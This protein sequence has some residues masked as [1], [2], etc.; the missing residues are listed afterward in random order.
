M[1]A[2]ETI[3]NAISSSKRLEIELIFQ[4]FFA[5]FLIGLV[6]AF[7]IFQFRNKVDRVINLIL[8]LFASLILLNY[9]SL[10]I[11]YPT[12]ADFADPAEAN[13]TSVSWLF[14]QGKPLYP[15]LDAAER[16]I[17]NYGALSYVIQSGFLNLLKPSLFSAKVAGSLAGFLSLGLVFLLIRQRLGWNAAIF[18][19]AIVSLC[20]LA[21]TSASGLL[22]SSFW[23][24]P[25]ALL[26]FFT[27][28]GLFLVVRGRKSIA[29]IG[30][31]IAL[32]ISTNLKITAFLHF[33]PIYVLL[34]YRFGL[35]PVL[36]SAGISL[37]VTVLPYLIFPQISF[38]N[39]WVWLQQVRLKGI[40]SE[41]IPKNLLWIGFVALPV[42]IAFLQSFFTNF[43]SFKRWLPKH[44]LYCVTLIIGIVI[45]AV[46]SSTRGALENN[47]LP[48]VPLLVYLAIELFQIPIHSRQSK[49]ITPINLSVTIAFTL[50]LCLAVYSTEVKFIERMTT[51]PGDQALADLDRI[52]AAN[53]NR[54]I[55]MGY[56]AVSYQLSTYRPP[57]VFAGNPYLLDSASLMEMQASGLN[58]TPENT[59]NALRTCQTNIWLIPR[60]NPP[61]QVYSYYPPLQ[62]LFSDEFRKTF[63]EHYERQF[64][65]EFYDAWVCKR[66][67]T[68]NPSQ[69]KL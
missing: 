48:F 45:N 25:D 28:L 42:V 47:M 33:I 58:N 44:L 7:I 59:L 35:I 61:F 23:V 6:P 27:V 66:S 65:S 4:G 57:L 50:S 2:L 34:L 39:Y 29:V 30:G 67:A 3:I 62:K 26:L 60:G 36:L 12:W 68:K 43:D 24:R 1:Q 20:F 54:T 13:V 52:M 56:G 19:T 16:Y 21:Q 51:A 9:I 5:L 46:I 10:I 38:T 49:I 69:E 31:A 64:T 63:A 55:E 14:H 41:Q 53:S 8:L 18:G 37:I 40:K 22:A 15:E 32:G 17:N 11:F